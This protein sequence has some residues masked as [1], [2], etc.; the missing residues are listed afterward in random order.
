MDALQT[1]NSPARGRSPPFGSLDGC[2][3]RLIGPVRQSITEIKP[4]NNAVTNADLI[5]Y[6]LHL[7]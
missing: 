6:L 7:S 4:Q 1:R 2:A 5:L 3:A